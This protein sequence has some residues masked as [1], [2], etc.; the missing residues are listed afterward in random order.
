MYYF[1]NDNMQFSKSGIEQA[2]INRLN[3]FKKNQVA[4][5]IVTR[6]FAMNLH[7]VLDGAQIADD[8]FVN[9]FDFFNGST[10]V[11]RQAFNLADFEVPA[12][13]IK[14]RKDNQVQVVEHGKLIMIIYLRAGTEAISNVQ[15]FDVNGRTLKMSWWDTRGFKCLEQLFD[16]TVKSP[17]KL[18][19]VPMGWFTSKRFTCST[20]PAKNGWLGGY[21]TI[22]VK[23]IHLMEWTS[24]P[25]SSMMS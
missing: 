21:W 12:D 14:T 24:W 20:M 17:R 18:T 3:L 1:L 8:D 15:Y 23:V 11:K 9:L 25:G 22:T 7:D 4:A 10:S 19:L 16:W 6:I 13:A 2:E 5:K